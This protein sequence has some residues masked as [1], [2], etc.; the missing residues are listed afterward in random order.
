MKT[1]EASTSTT[2]L[3]S[4][5]GIFEDQQWHHVVF[6]RPAG[7]DGTLYLD[8]DAVSTSTFTGSSTDALWIGLAET[9]RRYRA[10]LD[11]L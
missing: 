7:G 1:W 5:T 4:G 9:I 10:I 3:A 11:A 2:T 6:A 8:G